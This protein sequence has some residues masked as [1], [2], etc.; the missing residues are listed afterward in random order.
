MKG[1]WKNRIFMNTK[2]N[3]NVQVRRQIP[4]RPQIRFLTAEPAPVGIKFLDSYVE[5]AVFG[6]RQPWSLFSQGTFVPESNVF[7]QLT[8]RTAAS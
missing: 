6:F 3:L 4:V 5:P 7:R 8:G 1:L 2:L